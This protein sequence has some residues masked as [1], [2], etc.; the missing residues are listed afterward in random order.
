ML[1][2]G[3]STASLSFKEKLNKVKA[4]PCFDILDQVEQKGYY[5]TRQGEYEVLSSCCKWWQLRLVQMILQRQMSFTRTQLQLGAV[6][7]ETEGQELEKLPAEKSRLAN[8]VL[9][10]LM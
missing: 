1:D 8:I 7:M 3:S 9:C 10:I 2:T 4:F 6:A 5:E